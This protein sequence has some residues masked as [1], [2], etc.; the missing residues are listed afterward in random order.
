MFRITKEME[1]RF[2]S[3][4]LHGIATIEIK[5]KKVSD[6]EVIG[7]YDDGEEIHINQDMICAYWPDPARERRKER[8]KNAA[9]KRRAIRE[10]E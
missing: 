6:D 3:I 8:A 9:A 7:E 5:I 1:N 4:L 2:A 10:E